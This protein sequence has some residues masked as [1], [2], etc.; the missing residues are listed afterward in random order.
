MWIQ[1]TETQTTTVAER[2][3]CLWRIFKFLSALFQKIWMHWLRRMACRRFSPNLHSHFHFH[4]WRPR[5]NSVLCCIHFNAA[6]ERTNSAFS[7][8]SAAY[9]REWSNFYLTIWKFGKCPPT[10]LGRSVIMFGDQSHRSRSAAAV[11]EYMWLMKVNTVGGKI[12][13]PIAIKVVLFHLIVP[14]APCYW[15]AFLG[16]GSKS[17]TSGMT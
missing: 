8:A 16:S 4:L 11:K 15:K 3:A 10:F 17:A 12:L 13:E 9:P 14:C 7:S 5:D 2:C 1:Y 6:D